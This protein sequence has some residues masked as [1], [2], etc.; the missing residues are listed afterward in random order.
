MKKNILYI[1]ICS[2]ILHSGCTT[3]TELIDIDNDMSERAAGLEYR[4]FESAARSLVSEMLSSGNL[5]K[6][7]GGRYVLIISRIANDTMQRIDVDQ[8]SKKI[9]I[10]LINSGRVAV[11]N[12]EEDARVMQTRQLRNS[13]EVNQATVAKK[14]T[15]IAPELSLS[16]K[17]TQ[18]EFIISGDKRIEYTF[19]LSITSLDTG[20]T[21]WEGE[22]TI[23]KKTDKNAITW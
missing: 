5:T 21:L 22:K 3:R 2:L 18:R 13:R 4:D 1:A 10:E 20:L 14:G 23:I 8:L 7:S 11:S 9:R 17:I 12:I 15:L 19:A 16:G 6:P